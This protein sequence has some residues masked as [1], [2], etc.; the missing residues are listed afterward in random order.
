VKFETTIQG[1]LN[2]QGFLNR[3]SKEPS[4]DEHDS[5]E[6]FLPPS[7]QC[8]SNN[9]DGLIDHVYHGIDI[10][11]PDHYFEERCILSPLEGKAN[12]INDIML[13]RF[14]GEMYHLSS[15]TGACKPETQLPQGTG[16][17]PLKRGCPVILLRNVF[18][19]CRGVVTE[20]GGP[21]LSVRLFSGRMV[22]VRRTAM[23]AINGMVFLGFPVKL[24]FAMTIEEARGHAFFTLG[25]DLRYRLSRGQLLLALDTGVDPTGV[26][27]IG[28]TNTEASQT[29]KVR[30][31][32]GR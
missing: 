7:F 26:K 9:I 23:A 17:L 19:G 30:H 5:S 2:G 24:A 8:S 10:A 29:E 16:Y 3:I 15:I 32:N 20:L 6:L 13:Y 25:L 11:Q 27:C 22:T 28:G 21:F 31:F 18:K 12:Q 14:P 4:N 1:D